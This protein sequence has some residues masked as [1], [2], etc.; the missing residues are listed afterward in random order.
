MIKDNEDVLMI[1]K[2]AS[3]LTGEDYIVWTDADALEGF[4]IADYL[5]II[6]DLIKVI[7]NG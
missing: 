1:V 7:K 4:V 2:E 6:E 3:E 5:N